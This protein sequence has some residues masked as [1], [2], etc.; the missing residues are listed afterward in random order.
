MGHYRKVVIQTY[1]NSGDA[2]SKSVRANPI[3]GQGLD[4][5][6]KVRCSSSM[7]KKHPIGTLFLLEL[8][9]TDKEGGTPFLH[10]HH[11]ASYKVISANEADDFLTGKLK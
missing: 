8:K 7:R 1:V 11:D 2:S 6:M 4:V 9:V 10:A 3:P 5:N